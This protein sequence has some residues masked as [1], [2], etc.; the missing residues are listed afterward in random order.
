M[1]I[2]SH[3]Q[4][5]GD[6]VS[7]VKAILMTPKTEW[8]VIAAEPTTVADLYKNYI[9]IIAAIPAVMNFIQMSV[10]GI[11]IPFGGT[12]RTGIVS[13]ITSALV[14][15][16]MLLVMIFVVGLIID[17]LAPTFGGVKNQVQ[18]LKAAAY[19]ATAA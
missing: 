15:Y 5:S 11:T 2:D 1:S 19:S 3:P 7:R 13:G 18:A 8:P 17:A 4:G 12:I 14:Y 9:L 10:I 6:I 16:I